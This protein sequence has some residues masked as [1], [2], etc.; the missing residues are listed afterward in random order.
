MNPRRYERIKEQQGVRFFRFGFLKEELFQTVLEMIKM[1]PHERT[2]EPW[3]ASLDTASNR[4]MNTYIKRVTKLKDGE[5][6]IIKWARCGQ[7]GYI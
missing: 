1:G 4:R 5:H 2:L 6:Q 7:R 3:R